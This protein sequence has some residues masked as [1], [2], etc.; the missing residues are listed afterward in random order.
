MSTLLIICFIV[1]VILLLGFLYF[2]AKC[3]NLT[4]YQSTE[5]FYD[6][7]PPRYERSRPK[8]ANRYT[9]QTRT[10]TWHERPHPRDDEAPRGP[11]TDT[12]PT[13]NWYERFRNAIGNARAVP[14]HNETRYETRDEVDTHTLVTERARKKAADIVK[15]REMRQIQARLIQT[16]TGDDLGYNLLIGVD[17][18]PTKIGG[19]SV[20][21]QDSSPSIEMY[22][23]PS[24]K[25][26]WELHDTSMLGDSNEF[27]MKNLL[28]ALLL[29]QREIEE[30]GTFSIYTD[31]NAVSD[32]KS[33]YGRRV[34]GLVE[35][36]KKC[37][38][39]RLVDKMHVNRKK[40]WKLLRDL[41]NPQMISR[42]GKV[43]L[44]NPS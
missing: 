27:E 8:E 4:N 42:D 10:E 18:N 25:L 31:N 17:A 2:C 14:E 16:P 6:D 3:C 26:P 44:R 37:K 13:T 11:S 29:W 38:G 7:A 34:R 24:S 28:F 23:F 43:P 5:V 22:T 9:I 20:N 19:Y 35:H 33:V 40:M 21:F 12:N 39:V 32:F 15:V 1:V 30:A 36:L 41:F